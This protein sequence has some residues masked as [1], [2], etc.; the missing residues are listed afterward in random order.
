MRTASPARTLRVLL[1]GLVDYAGLFPP[2]ALSM[3]DAVAN[4]AA[5]LDSADAWALGRFVVTAERL[6]ELASE[7]ARYAGAD[8]APWRVSALIGERPADDAERI[9]AYNAVHVGALVVDTVEV[10]VSTPDAIAEAARALTGFTMF[11]ELP[12][13][14]NPDALVRGVKLVGARAK[15][16]TGGVTADVFP[17]AAKLARFIACCARHELPFK[18]TAGLHHPLRGEHRLTYESDAPSGVMFGFLNVFLAA[19]FARCGASEQVLEAVLEEREPA[20]FRFADDGV[21]WRDQRVSIAQ[22]TASRER[23][24]LAFGSCSFREPIDDLHQL[25]LL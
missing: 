14:E 15:V 25:A 18:A 1:E 19:A 7:A 17:P 6:D 21:Q 8:V 3:S 5:Y 13:A 11:V 24:A 12:L 9:R 23:L 10:R 16:R 2:A 20:A 22:L 4:Y